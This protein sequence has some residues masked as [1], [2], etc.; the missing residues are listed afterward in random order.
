[1]GFGPVMIVMMTFQTTVMEQQENLRTIANTH[2]V[3]V[4]V[5]IMRIA[6]LTYHI[7]YKDIAMRA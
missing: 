1:M 7:V 6:R 3:T 5:K 2:V 4:S